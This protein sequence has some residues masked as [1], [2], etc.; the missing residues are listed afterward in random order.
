M[1]NKIDQLT[2]KLYYEGVSKG[3]KDSAEIIA[4][5][6]AEAI[7]I[8]AKAK[9]DA[10]QIVEGAKAEASELSKNSLR[11]L[12]LASKQIVSDLKAQ[13]VNTVTLETQSKDV[14]SAFKSEEFV[15]ELILEVVKKWDKNSVK[16][17]VEEEKA[18]DIKAYFAKEIASKIS[19]S[20][21]I[22]SEKGVG[23]GFKIAPKE[24]GYYISFSDEEFD[25]L[26]KGYLKASLNS[27]L[28]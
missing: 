21:E 11:E 5:A 28:F 23:N 18:D 6:Q 7:D 14:A 9:A 22:V 19:K 25:N 12:T 13:I 8:V 24:G 15:K 20:V 3:L 2:K 4:K 27:I 1:E 16:V 26:L 17:L 10:A